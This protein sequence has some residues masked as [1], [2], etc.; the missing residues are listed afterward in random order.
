MIELKLKTTDLQ[1]MVSKAIKCA[2]NNKLI[3]ITSLM[4]IAVKGNVLTLTTTDATNYFYVHPTE[5]VLCEDFEISVI[6]D[7]FT[8]L[9]QKTTSDFI[10]LVI[11]G[12]VLKVK[13][14]GTYTMELPLDENGDVIKFPVKDLGQDTNESTIK[15]SAVKTVLNFNKPSLAVSVEYP[16]LTCY[17]CADKVV[18]SDRV[19]IC[20]TAIHMFDDPMLVSSS[21][22]ELLGVM[23]DE[24]IKVYRNSDATL[25]K[26]NTEEVFAPNTE[27]IETF[28]IQAITSLVEQD[29]PSNCKISR[30]LVLSVLDRLSLFVS[31]YD[32]RGIYLTFTKDGVT[33]SSKK[34]SGTELVPYITS[35]N[36]SEYTCCIDIEMF[37]SQVATQDDESIDLSYGTD[38]SIKMVTKNITQIVALSVDD[39]VE[40]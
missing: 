38:N 28:P 27:G 26:T 1:D 8:K 5:K 25:F 17:Y 10:T 39:R 14:N 22:M 34:S 20:S 30:Q 7:L 40:E 12:N 31:P 3:P 36:F 23:S 6:A 24:D 33:F 2:S 4:S 13:G 9:V 16:S 35:N 37:R 32:N 11:D 18:T 29:F 19:K 21:L 15:L